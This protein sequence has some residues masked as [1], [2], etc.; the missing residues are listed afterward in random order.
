MISLAGITTQTVSFSGEEDKIIYFKLKAGNAPGSGKVDVTATGNGTTS[1]CTI[2][3]PVLTA[4]A[5]VNRTTDYMIDGGKIKSIDLIPFGFK[6]TNEATL[7]FSQVGKVNFDERIRFL[8]QY[9]YGCAEQTTS[10][11]FAQ[12]YLPKVVDLSAPMIKKT[13]DHVRDGIDRLIRLQSGDGGFMYWP[14]ARTVDDWITSYAGHFLLEAMK[15]G[16]SVPDYVI[17]KWKEYQK[18]AA[19]NW[20]PDPK[21]KSFQFI[22]AYRLY[23]LALAGVPDFSSMNRL[24]EEQELLP[25]ASWRLAAAYALAG[26]HEIAQKMTEKLPVQT[27]ATNESFLTYGSDLRDRAMILETMIELNQFKTAILLAKELAASVNSESWLSTQETA[28]SLLSLDKY[29]TRYS[30]AEPIN[31]LVSLNGQESRYDSRKFSLNVPLK[32]NESG[33]NKLSVTNKSAVPL[34]V[35]LTESGIPVKEDELAFRKNLNM[36]VSWSGKDGHPIDIKKLKQGTEFRMT[37]KVSASNVMNGCRNLALTQIFPSGWEIENTRIGDAEPE[38]DVIPYNY[39]DF[40][41]DRVYTFF[42]LPGEKEKIFIF[43][44]TATYAG[45]FY[46]PGTYCEAMYDNSIAAKDKGMWVEIVRE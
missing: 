11:A 23:T 6:G 10:V 46:L 20:T 21:S 15:T 1:S 14:G 2:D 24:K 22:Q 17:S 31:V 7:E 26:K 45:R 27:R 34:L 35:R 19:K 3:I 40:R 30:S 37:V 29:Y 18:A 39:Q 5:F 12:L 41:D 9:P 8:I 25:A 13:E 4:S 28:Y 44:L 32:V 38:T 43:N 42:D 16:Y 33:S 36:Y